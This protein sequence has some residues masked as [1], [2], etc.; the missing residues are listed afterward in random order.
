FHRADP[1]R[2][3]DQA[4]RGVTAE[5]RT[6]LP[7]YTATHGGAAGSTVDISPL[8]GEWQNVNAASTD[9]RRVNLSAADGA[10][11]Q[12]AAAE[13]AERPWL[14]VVPFAAAPDSAVPIG[15]TARLAAHGIDAIV[16]GYATRGIL[17]LDCH[18]R[19]DD[20]RRDHLVREFFAR[21]RLQ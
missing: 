21:P 4:L 2:L 7:R 3:R 19:C 5:R 12:W 15:F 6:P 16:T 1:E 13:S 10:S 11:L 8:A 14:A 9:V 20:G 17:V 18:A